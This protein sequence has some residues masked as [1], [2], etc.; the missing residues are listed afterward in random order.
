MIEYASQILSGCNILD[1]S[2]KILSFVVS[3]MLSLAQINSNKFRKNTSIF[4][5]K[6]T[7]EEVVSIQKE[8]M[9]A[10]DIT[11]TTK[12]VGF[13]GNYLICTDQYRLQ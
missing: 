8:K 2:S 10:R 9:D 4:N 1:S 6:D 5:I 3:D 7:V 11:L 12:Y 13:S